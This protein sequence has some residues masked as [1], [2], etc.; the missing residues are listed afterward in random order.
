[1]ILLTGAG[2]FLGLTLLDHLLGAG[3][4]VVS[5]NDRPLHGGALARFEALPGRLECV[6]GDASDRTAIAG[7][8]AAHP[9][10]RVIHAAAITLGPAG[11]IAPAERVLDVNVVSTA[12]LVEE[13]LKAGVARFVYPSSSAVYGTAVFD[14]APVAEDHVPTPAGLYGFTKLASERLLE[15]ARVSR[16][17]PAVRAR[18]T[19]VF[20]PYEHDTG[21]R[22]TLSPP[23]QVAMKALAGET[24]RL[25]AGGERD[26]TSSRD[27]ARALATLALADAAPSEVYNLSLGETWHPRL[28]CEAFATALPGFSWEMA[29]GPDGDTN[30][31]FNDDLSR[32][33]QP[34]SAARFSSDFGFRFMPPAEAAAD[35][36]DWILGDGRAF[37]AVS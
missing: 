31:A 14:G 13:A 20:G 1:M 35:F 37:Y 33:R 9:I 18:V 17:L 23:F 3:H 19:A 12:H 34:I 15:S 10:D 25:P 8:F 24:V 16:G 26:W 11:T 28:L 6:T 22:E 21:V 32:T 30:V 7:V 36:A 29:A 4:D 5:F 2:G 27:V